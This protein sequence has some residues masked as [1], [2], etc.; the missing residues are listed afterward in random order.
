[1]DMRRPNNCSNCPRRNMYVPQQRSAPRPQQAKTQA[2]APIQ[3][4]QEKPPAFGRCY[5]SA[6]AKDFTVTP[7]VQGTALPLEMQRTEGSYELRQGIVS[8]PA[9]GYYML[10]WETGITAAEGCAGLRIGINDA[11][12][13]INTGLRP[14]YDSGQQVTWL[15]EGDKLSIQ[16]TGE[17]GL[18]EVQGSS[19]QLTV[20][21]M[22]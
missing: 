17:A 6:Y 8:I 15:A 11:G 3:A 12:M 21:R 16:V 4:A 18:P 9:D 2:A 7:S 20:L 22:G 1:M 14:G 5:L 10:L 13:P 19:A